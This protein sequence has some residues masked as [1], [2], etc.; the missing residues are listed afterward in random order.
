VFHGRL[1]FSNATLHSNVLPDKT[2]S[3]FVSEFTAKI[4]RFHQIS[5]INTIPN[6]ASGCVLPYPV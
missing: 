6:F 1:S 2:Q 4:I 5:G 3:N